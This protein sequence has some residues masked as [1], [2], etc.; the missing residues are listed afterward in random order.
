M[1]L[2]VSILKWFR[3][4]YVSA[5]FIYA[6][7]TAQKIQSGFSE[8]VPDAYKAVDKIYGDLNK[9]GV[10]DCVLLIKGTEK[11]LIV[12]DA[13]GEELDHNRRGIIVLFK[14]GKGYILAVKNYACFSSE[15]EDGGVYF[16]PELSVEIQQ[17]KLYVHYAHG[18]YGY[19]RYTLQY[20]NSDFE[21]IGYDESDNQG[22]VVNSETSINFLSKRK[23]IRINVNRNSE[24]GDEV[25]EETWS[26]VKTGKP[27][28]L[29]EIKSFD[30]PYEMIY[31][32]M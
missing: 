14:K 1:L 20:R 3:Y 18:R 2:S 15:N 19:W 28:K 29:S 13:N 24:G 12:K 25:F 4:L 11:G 16:P 5:F 32:R 30:D 8:F 21:L 7:A 23:K 27:E 6:D 22:P 10:E 31:K 26:E 17:G 9:D